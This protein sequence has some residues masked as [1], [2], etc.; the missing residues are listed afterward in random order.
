MVPAIA[1]ALARPSRCPG[2]MIA[3]DS[4]DVRCSASRLLQGPRLVLVLLDPRRQSDRDVYLPRADGLED[5]TGYF[6]G[7]GPSSSV[8]SSG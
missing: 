8:A 4:L 2:H 3:P 7:D 5:L 6:T 1:G